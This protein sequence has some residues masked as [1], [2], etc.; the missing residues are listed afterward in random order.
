[1]SGRRRAK[2]PFEHP[3]GVALGLVFNV[4][5]ERIL[6]PQWASVARTTMRAGRGPG[7]GCGLFVLSPVG[8]PE[9]HIV[10]GSALVEVGV[11]PASKLALAEVLTATDLA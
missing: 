10:H 5:P 11:N 8:L 6:N 3:M 4:T 2:T 1:M 9:N 7:F